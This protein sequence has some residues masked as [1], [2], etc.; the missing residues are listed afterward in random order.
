MRART[1][2]VSALL[3]FI[4]VVFAQPA[5]VT[6]PDL[7]AFIANMVERHGMDAAALRD[8]LTPLKPV[9]S[10]VKAVSAPSTSRPWRDYRPLN[11][12]KT[13]I[14][15]GVRFWNAN[16]DVL[17]RARQ[18][19]GVPESIITAILAVET[20]FGRIT[21]THRVLDA[22]FTLGFDV[23]G[24]NE[25]FKSE[26]ENFLLLARERGWDPGTVKGS[27]A[28]AMGMPQFMPSSYRQYAVDFGDNGGV[29]LWTDTADVVGSVA[30][31]LRIFGWRDG[32]PVAMPAR[33][34]GSDLEGMLAR[35]IRPHAPLQELRADGVVPHSETD[36]AQMASLFMLEGELGPE[37]W[38]AF[39]NLNAVLQ[40]NRSRN[41]AMSVYLLALEIARE[42][43]RLAAVESARGAE[44]AAK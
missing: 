42:R 3:A 13:R 34:E 14:E 7:E 38:I 29:D 21:G 35:G 25:Y 33:Y 10:I 24:R 44:A 2:A 16:A 1:L 30:N 20:R 40:Y 5:P 37:Y 28:G 18:A 32:E 39:N 9:P 6:R 8:L 19:Y 26:L 36:G 31:F 43:E 11:V 27:F 17:A 12:D 15:G 23:P 41:Y 4:T 22:L